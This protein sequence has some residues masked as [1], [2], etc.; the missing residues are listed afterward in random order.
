VLD[1]RITY[2]LLSKILSLPGELECRVLC[3]F[4]LWGH[5]GKTVKESKE[6]CFE[7]RG[8]Y[9][10]ISHNLPAVAMLQNPKLH[11]EKIVWR[12]FFLRRRSS[13]FSLFVASYCY[14]KRNTVG[15]PKSILETEVT[16]HC[17]SGHDLKEEKSIHPLY[18]PRKK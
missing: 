18:F 2:I 9:Y 3:T 1:Y 10:R 5:L 6:S 15:K 4:A 14:E 12:N 8:L 13:E 11:S 16:S 17:K 7:F